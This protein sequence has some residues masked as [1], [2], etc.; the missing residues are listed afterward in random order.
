MTRILLND[1]E[2]FRVCIENV[3]VCDNA[4][5]SF[6]DDLELTIKCCALKKV[7]GEYAIISDSLLNDKNKALFNRLYWLLNSKN[8]NKYTVSPIVKDGGKIV[9]KNLDNCNDTQIRCSSY[10]RYDVKLCNFKLWFWHE[11]KMCGISYTST[12]LGEV[13][14]Y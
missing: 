11:K 12:L 3:Y 2:N 8:K 14:L 9:L 5:Y 7:Y 10:V 6:G 13:G 1:S 4:I